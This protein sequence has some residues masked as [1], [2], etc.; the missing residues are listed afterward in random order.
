MEE[1]L[2]IETPEQVELSYELAG[3]GSRFAA[4]VID[5]ILVVLVVIILVVG[6]VFLAGLSLSSFA[7]FF[8]VEG[9]GGPPQ[10]KFRVLSWTTALFVLAVFAVYWGYFFFFEV[11]TNGRTP[12]KKELGLRVIRDGG[13]PITVTAAA[14]RNLMRAVD[15]LPWPFYAV[16]GVTILFSS[17]SK[18]LGDYAAG[19]VVI[20]E[21]VPDYTAKT[22]KRKRSRAQP[23]QPGLA[24]RYD[25]RLSAKEAAIVRS[26]LLRRSELNKEARER[27]AREIAQPLMERMGV[28]EDDPEAFLLRLINP[29]TE[30]QAGP[31][32]RGEPPSAGT[33]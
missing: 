32:G 7:D 22:D 26:F 1:Q 25:P 29:P 15:A 20:K 21:R 19:T 31:T 9:E 3:L 14:V 24:E 12:G 28:Q 18:R 2:V 10:F 4:G 6:L 11:V 5:S 33:R 30:K 23:E 16:A 27:L 8:D 17:R 13:Y